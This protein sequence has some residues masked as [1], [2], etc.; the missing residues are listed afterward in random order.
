MRQHRQGRDFRINARLRNDDAAI[1]VAD[2][3]GWSALRIDHPF[4]GIDVGRQ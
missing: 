1:R 3:N 2:E 4:G